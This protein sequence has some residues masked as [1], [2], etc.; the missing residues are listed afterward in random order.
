MSGLLSIISMYYPSCSLRLGKGR[1]LICANCWA[2]N[3][4]NSLTFAPL[5]IRLS[6]MIVLFIS[7]APS[8]WRSAHPNKLLFPS[9]LSCPFPGLQDS[10]WEAVWR[11]TPHPMQCNVVGMYLAVSWNPALPL[12]RCVIFYELLSNSMTQPSLERR[13][14]SRSMLR[15]LCM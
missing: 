5:L 10:L 9:L 3:S 11:S 15:G 8:F 1:F 6:H 14:N 2:S 12:T 13:A 7:I 4:Q